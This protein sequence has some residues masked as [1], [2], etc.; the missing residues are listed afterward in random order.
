MSYG[1][2]NIADGC[3]PHH[4]GGFITLQEIAEALPHGS[5]IDCDWSADWLSTRKPRAAFY[6][7][8]HAMNEGGM[9]DGYGDFRVEVF[10]H[11]TTKYN[12]L[13]G[14][15]EGKAQILHAIGDLD[16]RV[17]G[18]GERRKSFYG[19]KEYIEESVSTCLGPLG[20]GS[21]RRDI[22]DIHDAPIGQTR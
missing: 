15:L 13:S 16:F 19:V 1:I 5:G 11:T 4:D 20:I 8:Y 2:G 22:I 10:V 3:F 21:V 6:N 18:P 12:E 17:V 14:P 9:Y 7:S